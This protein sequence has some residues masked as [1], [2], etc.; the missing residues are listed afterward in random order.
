MYPLSILAQKNLFDEF[1]NELKNPE[2]IFETKDEVFNFTDHTIF[3]NKYNSFKDWNCWNNN[4]EINLDC[5][6]N[7]FCFSDVKIDIPNNYFKDIK[8]I[9]PLKCPHIRCSCD[10]LLK[11]KKEK[12]ASDFKS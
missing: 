9:V 1:I 3:E 12:Y 5:Q 10:G 6:I 2:F 8:T 11:V 7:Q 4:Y